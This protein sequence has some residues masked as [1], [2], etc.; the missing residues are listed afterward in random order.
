MPTV[1]S[2]STWA[3]FWRWCSCCTGILSA[4][5][6]LPTTSRAPGSTSGIFSV[7]SRR[8]CSCCFRASRS[9]LRPAAA[10]GP[11]QRFSPALLKRTRRFGLFLLLGYAIHFP[12]PRF[13]MLTTLTDEQRRSLFQVDVLQLIGATFLIIQAL[14]LIARSR[15]LFTVAAFVLAAGV[16]AFTHPVWA[17]DWWQRFPAWLAAYMSPARGSLFPLFPWA[18][19]VLFGAGS[20]TDLCQLGC[21]SP[22][23]LHH[24]RAVRAWSAH[25]GGRAGDSQR[26]MTHPGG[27]TPGI[28]CPSSWRSA[29]APA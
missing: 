6:S 8:V 29:L 26:S 12:V 11:H 20:G 22:S 3:G 13:S 17:I 24:P 25:V 15:R 5:C 27:R 28:S 9:A 2:S 7:A 10:G 19:Y 14:V 1:S 16:L 23:E 21:C 18:T 4:R